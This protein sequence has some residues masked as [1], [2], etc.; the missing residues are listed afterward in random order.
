MINDLSCKIISL[1][2]SKEVLIKGSGEL[3]ENTSYRIQ[4]LLSNAKLSNYPSASIFTTNIQNSYL[5]QGC[6]YIAS[7]SI[8][9]YFN[10]AL[11]IRETDIKFSGSFTEDTEITIPNHGLLTG[12][13]VSYVNGGDDN[14]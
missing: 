11:D 7:P 14:K 13:N 1:I 3:S 12:D 4:R 2:S 8:P 6:V 9:S 10:D 5:D